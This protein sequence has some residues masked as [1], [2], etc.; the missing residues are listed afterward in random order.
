MDL[1]DALDWLESAVV[2][3]VG[4]SLREPEIVIL[5]GTW[6]G[7]TYE[8]MAQGSEYSTNYLM[9]DVAPKLW[10]QLSHVFGC[11]VGK[12]NFRV[13]LEAYIANNASL[14]P[15][16]NRSALDATAATSL[17]WHPAVISESLRS[18]ALSNS[19]LNIGARH[20]LLMAAHG[21]VPS[22]MYGYQ[23][24]LAQARQW[25]NA[26][27]NTP[28]SPGIAALAQADSRSQIIGI[29]GLR[30]VGKTLF[31]EQLVAQVGDRFDAVIWRS[32]KDQP[33]LNDLSASILVHIG[34]AP[35]P[36]QATAQLLTIMA[37]KSLLLV[38]EGIEALLRP[39]CLAG[40]Y[41]PECQAYGDF[42]Q[43]IIGLKSSVIITGIEG[44][45]DLVRRSGS[46]NGFGSS[47]SSGISTRLEPELIAEADHLLDDGVDDGI[48]DEIGDGVDDEIGNS[49]LGDGFSQASGVR[50]LTLSQLCEADATDLLRAESL[51]TP[52]YWPELI[53]RYQGH[54]LALKTASRVI[55]EIFNGRV[56]EFLRQA[57]VLFTDILRLIAPSFERLSPLEIDILY[58]LASQEAPLS[59]SELQQ[60][61]PFSM[62][63]A[64][65]ISAL[66]SLNQRSLLAID[67][68]IASAMGQS[69]PQASPL[70]AS[71]HYAP[72]LFYLP[73][74][75]KAY[76]I[77]Q[78]VSQ[79]GEIPTASNTAAVPEGIINLSASQ[80]NPVRLNRWFQ[81]HFNTDWQP[82][83]RLFTAATQPA[84]R[85]RSAYHLRDDTFVKRYKSIRLSPTQPNPSQPSPLAAMNTAATTAAE[86]TY[87][88]I[89]LVAVHQDDEDLYRVCVQ[90]QPDREDSVLPE[91]IQLNL[92]DAEKN[93]L[94]SVSAAQEDNFIQLPYF[95]G[96]LAERFDIELVL[97][98]THHTELFMI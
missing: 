92:L 93:I 71:H 14:A 74:L 90:L 50:S 1:T 18:A 76:A 38:L 98:N 95:R 87:R 2:N 22:V 5:K 82:L 26:A 69:A 24:A 70:D 73:A 91:N 88:A 63:A 41:L 8:Q 96:A 64:D 44:P 30:G 84:M 11:S 10:K 19:L 7:L 16:V 25:L 49:L 29:W 62:D 32:L 9:R 48:E 39:G 34:V 4:Q 55:R 57:S 23:Q 6:R 79:F 78:L 72:P 53:R 27:A 52:E 60:T 81:G 80:T 31:T 45:A 61:L 13:A 20:T 15:S 66:D 28:N 77:N 97:G 17:D 42:L 36:E 3:T 89:L 51:A 59:L 40:D 85:L 58:W 47:I 83:H 46:G 75:V 43:A 35:Q 56:D 67:T 21:G 65:L 33:T 68:S 54:P 37:Q 12:T 94:V 86:N